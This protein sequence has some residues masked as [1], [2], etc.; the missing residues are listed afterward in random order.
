MRIACYGKTS[1]QVVSAIHQGA[2]ALGLRP[3]S[4]NPQAFKPKET[5]TA[6]VAVAMGLARTGRAV[7]DAYQA[8]GT[9]VLVVDSGYILRDQGYYQI[10][11]EDLNSLPK[12]APH[13]RAQDMGLVV[14]SKRKP[15]P[16]G[17]ILV[18]AQK[19]GDNQHNIDVDQ[20]CQDI[21]SQLAQLTSRPVRL[22]PHPRVQKPKA[23]LQDELAGCHCMVTHN[24]TAAYEAIMAGVPVICDPC[25][26]YADVCETDLS[27]VE[28]PYCG[29]KASR[30][31]L[32]NRVAY[33][34]WTIE[35]MRSG[36]ALKFI[37][38]R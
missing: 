8:I 31:K 14:A 38:G 22:R 19:P 11:W 30:Q 2:E 34:Q 25:A 7:R 29:A 6:D 32:M 4:R 18:C 26:A 37:L 35:E 1:N 24:S 10:G 9:P 16:E 15:V 27:K 17:H 3:F 33:G 20:W 21:S 5:S 23:T 13:D 12:T 28:N 36:E